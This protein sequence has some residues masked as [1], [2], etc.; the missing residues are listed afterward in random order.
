[1]TKQTA[2]QKNENKK[3]QGFSSHFIQKLAAELQAVQ[4]EKR[5]LR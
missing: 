1:M 4:T 2:K 3:S 5:Q